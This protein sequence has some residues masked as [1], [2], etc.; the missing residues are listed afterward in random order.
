MFF[1]SFYLLSACV[2]APM[3]KM[4]VNPMNAFMSVM[5]PARKSALRTAQTAALVVMLSCGGFDRRRP[6]SMM[7]KMAMRTSMLATPPVASFVLVMRST[8]L[9]ALLNPVMSVMVVVCL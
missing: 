4:S 1:S 3:V 8:K 7:M 6:T 5:P 9:V 2:I